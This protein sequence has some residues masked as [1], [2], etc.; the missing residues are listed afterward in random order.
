MIATLPSLN[1][2]GYM[3]VQHSQLGGSFKEQMEYRH[4]TLVQTLL[5]S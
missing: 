4:V 2:A 5:N 3:Y 1:I